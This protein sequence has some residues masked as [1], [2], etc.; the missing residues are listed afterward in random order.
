MQRQ[1]E[2]AQ[3][4]EIAL[5]ASVCIGACAISWNSLRNW[6]G[7]RFLCDDCRFN[8]PELCKKRER[9]RALICTAYECITPPAKP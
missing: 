1:M 3:I 6:R 8:D 5:L 2:P 7:S 9:G 4:I